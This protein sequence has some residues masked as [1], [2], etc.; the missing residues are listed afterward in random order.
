MQKLKENDMKSWWIKVLVCL[1]AVI[2]SSCG[3]ATS[4][5][6]EKLKLGGRI[7]N[8]SL[9]SLDGSTVTDRSFE[10]S[11]VVLNFW[12][13]W[14]APC[15]KEIPDLKKVAA[16]SK[17]KVLGIALDED[18]ATAVRPFVERNGINYPVAF[19]NQELFQRFNG[20]GI[21][22]TLVLD[23]SQR[24]VNIYRGPV[25]KES[26]EQDLKKVEQGA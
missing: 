2:L 25:T 1:S 24:I 14:C 10:G 3:D 22:Y 4:G 17:V 23:R 7:P 11:V 15:M 16:D 9:K 19:G 13:T 18:E 12:A 6:P 8:F 26:L 20:L 5:S 21:P